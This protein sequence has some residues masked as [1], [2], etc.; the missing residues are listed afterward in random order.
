MVEVE[1]G[2]GDESPGVGQLPAQTAVE[3]L[4]AGEGTVHVRGVL[5]TD[6]IHNGDS[7]HNALRKQDDMT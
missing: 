2:D 5:F 1:L 3:S 4:D 6:D 7:L